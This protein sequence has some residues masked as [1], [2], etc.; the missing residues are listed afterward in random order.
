MGSGVNQPT[1]KTTS[2]KEYFDE[3]FVYA[4]SI[5]MSYEQYWYE[6]TD[7]LNAYI[8]AEQIRQKKRN[9]EMWLQ[10]AYIYN[11][12]GSLAPILN[13]MV[14]NPKAQPYMQSPIPLTEEDRIEQHN[15]KVLNFER[16]LKMLAQRGKKDGRQ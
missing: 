12:V 13:G 6:D 15:Q 9:N 4:L 1:D 7:L 2:L 8:K 10:G 5:G 3:L 11:A 14:K 16:Q